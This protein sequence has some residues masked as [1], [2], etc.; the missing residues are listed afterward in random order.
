MSFF[1]AITKMN[2][3]SRKSKQPKNLAE[4][5]AHILPLDETT[6]LHPDQTQAKTDAQMAI[7]NAL[8][9]TVLHCAETGEKNELF[10]IIC[11]WCN[12]RTQ[13]D[14][15]FIYEVV[16][17]AI[18]TSVTTSTAIT[19]L[20]QKVPAASMPDTIKIFLSQISQIDTTPV[21]IHS[22]TVEPG[23]VMDLK[24]EEICRPDVSK[25][26]TAMARA[27]AS[28]FAMA[29]PPRRAGKGR[30]TEGDSQ[31]QSQEAPEAKVQKIDSHQAPSSSRMVTP[32]HVR[33][34]ETSQVVR[35]SPGNRDNTMTLED[36]RAVVMKAVDDRVQ[37]GIKDTV[38]KVANLSHRTSELETANKT[39]AD[40]L[41]KT[42]QLLASLLG[43]LPSAGGG[44]T[45]T[46]VP[47]PG[48]SMALPKDF[49][50]YTV[51]DFPAL[52]TCKSTRALNAAIGEDPVLQMVSGGQ[53]TS[54]PPGP[55]YEYIQAARVKFAVKT[56]KAK[57]V[58]PATIGAGGFAASITKL[59][60]T[61]TPA[62]GADMSTFL[63]VAVAG[64]T[65]DATG[66]IAI[67][68]TNFERNAAE[69]DSDSD[70]SDNDATGTKEGEPTP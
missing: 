65:P 9:E 43:G 68:T 11:Y 33:T 23:P 44:G 47:V 64:V 70:N 58:K 15:P 18:T 61:A 49:G 51:A 32:Y 56:T 2:Q 10:Q 46:M 40:S 4:L 5:Q 3:M 20:F 54:A 50:A 63:P 8:M 19:E 28:V 48:T 55:V 39:T 12:T 35:L 57:P 26:T 36:V 7:Y 60:P 13:G 67:E 6:A 62:T 16:K 29:P 27:A 34:P 14:T 42:A 66:E 59:T 37:L 45:P 17:A 30:M 25:Y 1:D 69:E 52:S 21:V 31:L 22:S 53:S 24:I 38:A 41:A